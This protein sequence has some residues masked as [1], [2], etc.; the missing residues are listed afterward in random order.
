M[1]G[2]DFTTEAVKIVLVFD[3]RCVGLH[4]RVEYNNL[5]EWMKQ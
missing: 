3:V 1:H 2:P 4:C 5:F